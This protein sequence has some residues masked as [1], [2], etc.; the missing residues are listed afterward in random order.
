MCSSG[1]LKKILI[2][3]SVLTNILQVCGFSLKPTSQHFPGGR[4]TLR[5]TDNKFL[6]LTQSLKNWLKTKDQ[7]KT[8][9]L[10]SRIAKNRSKAKKK[11]RIP[12]FSS[13]K[14]YPK[15]LWGG[16]LFYFT[17]VSGSSSVSINRKKKN[18]NNYNDGGG[19]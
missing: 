11:V 7:I 16:E 2:L 8:I 12:F 18:N 19:G 13:L 6:V 17:H 5:V 14:C 3:F 9:S 1:Y 10:R 15:M 4:L